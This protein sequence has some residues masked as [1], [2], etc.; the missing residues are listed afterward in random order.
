METKAADTFASSSAVNMKVTVWEYDSMYF[1]VKA[2]RLWTNTFHIKRRKFRKQVLQ[3]AVQDYKLSLSGRLNICNVICISC[4]YVELRSSFRSLM[5]AE[6]YRLYHIV[7]PS[8]YS[9]VHCDV[10]EF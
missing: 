4:K 1:G 10:F 9:S 2:P 5:D 8:A 7:H 6:R 3:V